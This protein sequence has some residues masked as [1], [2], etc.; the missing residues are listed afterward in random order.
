MESV[1]V[2][3]SAQSRKL[4]GARL[5]S[6][7]A[8][9]SVVLRETTAFLHGRGFAQLLPVIV[10]PITD[11]L[12]HGVA[13]AEIDYC[14]SRFQLTKSMILHKQLALAAPGAGRLF[15]ISPNVRL[16]RPERAS[17]GRHLLEFTQADFEMRGAGAAEAMSLTEDLFLLVFSAVMR[18]CAAELESVGRR[19]VL[20]CAPFAVR[21]T[22]ELEAEFGKGWEAEF[23]RS[24][25]APAWVLD[26]EREFYDR[27]D[28]ARPGHYAN[29]DLIYPEGFGEALSGGEREHEYGRIVE[30]MRRKAMDLAPYA[31]YLEAARQ[32]LLSPSAGAGFGIE[33]MVRFLCGFERIEDVSP[34]AKPPG[35]R[36]YVF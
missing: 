30:R 13:D 20:P 14:G 24:I 1:P 35:A 22:G 5:S 25:S 33:R 16:E 15:I 12:N 10:P 4:R 34:F 3:V 27:E 26:H 31:C 7:L 2:L 29:Y 17:T 19:L 21:S 36:A 32:G 28:A 8:V 18:E 6:A 11:P 9:Q 23:S